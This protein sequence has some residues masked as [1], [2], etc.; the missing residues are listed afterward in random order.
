MIEINRHMAAPVSRHE[1]IE[2]GGNQHRTT[3]HLFQNRGVD[4]LK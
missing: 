3:F 1:Q 4:D 2:I